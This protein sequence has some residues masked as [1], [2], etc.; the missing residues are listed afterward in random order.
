MMLGIL[1]AGAAY[2][3]M[4]QFSKRS[5]KHCPAGIRKHSRKRQAWARRILRDPK[6]RGNRAMHR[7]AR[8]LMALTRKSHGQTRTWRP[9]SPEDAK[10]LGICM[11][12]KL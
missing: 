8:R 12:D 9:L 5:Y 1:A 4:V 7:A 10:L 6:H 3:L 11:G 2:W